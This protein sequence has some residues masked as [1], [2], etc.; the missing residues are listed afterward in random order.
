VLTT[1]APSS[2]GA[3]RDESHGG[4]SA[5]V[6]AQE[7]R[8][9]AGATRG[10]VVGPLAEQGLN[11]AFRRG[12]IGRHLVGA[13]RTGAARQARPND[14]ACRLAG[15]DR[16]TV[17]ARRVEPDG[18]GDTALLECDGRQVAAAVQDRPS[19][20]RRTSWAFCPR[21]MGGWIPPSPST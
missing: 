10:G 7:R 9:L 6:I 16:P 3:K 11:E 13:S 14:S 5:V 20:G 15:T 12:E 2:P 19:I 21:S 18:R 1:T 8:E 4:S 17:R